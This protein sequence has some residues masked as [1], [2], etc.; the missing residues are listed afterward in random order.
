MKF[1][2]SDRYYLEIGAHVF[3]MEKYHLL[4]AEL[5]KNGLVQKSDFIEPPPP[6][7]D[8]ML[9]VHTPE[10]IDDLQKLRSTPRTMY[11]ELPLTREI[12]EGYF[13]MASGTTL[14]GQLALK[15]GIGFHIGGGFHHAFA[16]HAEGFCY[17][18]DIAVCLQRLLH[19]KLIAR[20]CVIDCDLH[21]GNGTANIFREDPRVFTFSIHQEDLYPVKQQSDWDIG[22]DN[23]TGDAGYLSKLETAVKKIFAVHQPEFCV[24]VAGADP[25][26][27]DQ[28]GNL[29]L[30]KEGLKKRDELVIGEARKNKIPVVVV[31]AGGY[32]RRIE[33]TVEI[34]LNTCTVGKAWDR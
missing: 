15:H 28:L 19:D 5:D 31:L 1:V 16:D 8:D 20:A 29:R 4:K 9:L 33:D 12:V 10:Y 3:P 24:Y 27:G 11:S 14:A 21:Q 30:T 7:F 25:F 18:N 17:I 23:G 13:L 22:L 2:Y 34:H 32:A 26:E 6:A